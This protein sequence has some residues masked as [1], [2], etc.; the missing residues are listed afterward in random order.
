MS[1]TVV[2]DGLVLILAFMK[3]F[4]MLVIGPTFL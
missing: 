2:L 3:A 4:N 1:K